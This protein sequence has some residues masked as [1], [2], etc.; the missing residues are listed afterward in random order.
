L[1]FSFKGFYDLYGFFYPFDV[2]KCFTHLPSL[3][4]LKYLK[5]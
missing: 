4:K 3:L 5:I 1:S 2:P